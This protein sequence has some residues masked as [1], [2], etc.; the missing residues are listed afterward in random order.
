MLTFSA[1]KPGKTFSLVSSPI[2]LFNDSKRGQDPVWKNLPG[3]RISDWPSFAANKRWNRR[4]RRKKNSERNRKN[5][6][7]SNRLVKVSGHIQF[8]N[9]FFLAEKGN[10]V[11]VSIVCVPIKTCQRTA[12]FLHPQMQRRLWRFYRTF[13]SGCSNLSH[14]SEISHSF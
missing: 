9:A 14:L 8:V 2:M 10:L 5:R 12:T 7:R 3:A 1:A 13:H 4:E 11:H 6:K